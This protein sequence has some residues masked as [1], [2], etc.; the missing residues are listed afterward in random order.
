[1]NQSFIVV[2][3]TKKDILQ[4]YISLIF[5]NEK[6]SQEFLSEIKFHQSKILSDNIN[7]Y[8]IIGKVQS[9]KTRFFLGLIASLLTIYD[10]IILFT[11]TTKSLHQQTYLRTKNSLN[12]IN[13]EVIDTSLP[14]FKLK[15]KNI[16]CTL[17]HHQQIDKL[18]NIL[19]SHNI[20]NTILID[21]ESDQASLNNYNYQNIFALEPRS[22]AT[23]ESIYLL[24]KSSVSKYIQ[25]TATPAAHLLTDKLDIFSPDAIGSL[26][27]HSNYAGNEIFF[28]NPDNYSII[29]N[30]NLIYLKFLLTFG[31]NAFLLHNSKTSNIE[32][33]SGLIL[34]DYKVK[35]NIS[36]AEQLK[37]DLK[38]ILTS[39]ISKLRTEY[40]E[41][42]YE[43]SEE[44]ISNIISIL[45]LLN[46][47][48]VFQ[49]FDDK[50]NWEEYYGNNKF[51]ILVGGNK[52]QRGFTVKGL[53]TTLLTRETKSKSNADTVQQ[54]ARFFGNKKDIIQY[55][56]V[57]CTQKVYEQFIEYKDNENLIYQS[58]NHFKYKNELDINLNFSLTNPTRRGVISRFSDTI[59]TNKFY[60]IYCVDTKDNEFKD[61]F[62]NNSIYIEPI[63]NS[64]I[65]GIN[66]EKFFQLISEYFI[67][68]KRQEVILSHLK[69]ILFEDKI[70]FVNLTNNN[71]TFRTRNGI[72]SVL[73]NRYIPEAIHQGRNE[74]YPGD[75]KL[76]IKDQEI[77]IHS[78]YNFLPNTNTNC[79]SLLFKFK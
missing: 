3:K 26:E 79:F 65:Y 74:N 55:C 70:Q 59:N 77:T 40:K 67:S 29:K 73:N 51:F 38:T 57:L 37:Y 13:L 10:N 71:N 48:E 66:R 5:D 69:E 45:K 56:K 39:D 6:Q 4:D 15:E 27:P 61:K 14:T 31:Y 46:I 33:I 75:S 32:N 28:N 25:I 20:S 8:L 60:T 34:S 54:R 11:G 35:N 42:F 41:L 7:R 49:K 21:D 43:Y 78:S 47:Q 30:N 9:G 16:F 19:S 17:K 12:A 62:F 52:I 53:I 36:I 58:I 63:Y 23:N 50:I 2:G 24:R 72:F 44:D 64:S 22:S 68:N 76:L 1:M 18:K